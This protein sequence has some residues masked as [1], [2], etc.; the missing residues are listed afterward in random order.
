MGIKNRR[1]YLSL[2]QFKQIFPKVDL[3]IFDWRHSQVKDEKWTRPSRRLLVDSH[4]KVR[5]APTSW[6]GLTQTIVLSVIIID[7]VATL[8]CCCDAWVPTLSSYPLIMFCVPDTTQGPSGTDDS[9]MHKESVDQEEAGPWYGGEGG[10]MELMVPLGDSLARW[11]SEVFWSSQNIWAKSWKMTKSYSHG[12]QEK[13]IPGRY[14][15]EDPE[16]QKPAL[17]CWGHC[18]KT[19]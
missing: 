14:A 17:V 4:Q 18:N 13:S 15:G 11:R 16:W 2:P 3:F 5:A 9:R 12:D 8:V 10:L 7:S 19:L 6:L 1:M